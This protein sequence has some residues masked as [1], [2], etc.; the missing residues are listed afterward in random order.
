MIHLLVIKFYLAQDK[1][2]LQAF[3]M[4]AINLRSP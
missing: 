1:D 4:A 3:V 2:K